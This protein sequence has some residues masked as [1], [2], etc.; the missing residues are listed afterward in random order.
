MMF[1]ALIPVPSLI[2]C[3]CFRRAGSS[4][5]PIDAPNVMVRIVAQAEKKA[6]KTSCVVVAVCATSGVD[7]NKTA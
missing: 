4:L 1:P 6:K 7:A 3:N 5:T 2:S